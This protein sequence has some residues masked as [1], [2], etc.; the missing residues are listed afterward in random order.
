[1]N[2]HR[3]L[4]QGVQGVQLRVGILTRNHHLYIDVRHDQFILM[5]TIWATAVAV[6]AVARRRQRNPETTAKPVRQVANE[7]HFVPS[8]G[9]NVLL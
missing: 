6:M 3:K 4:A 5:M 8:C 2:L 7:L 1:M 9:K